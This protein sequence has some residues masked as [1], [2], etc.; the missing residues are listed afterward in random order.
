MI[1][2]TTPTRAFFSSSPGFRDTVFSL[3]RLYLDTSDVSAGAGFD[4]SLSSYNKERLDADTLYN[5]ELFANEWL[6]SYDEHGLNVIGYSLT[7]D[8]STPRESDNIYC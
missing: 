7:Q 6:K 8:N 2:N 5:L 3:K 4:D 1:P